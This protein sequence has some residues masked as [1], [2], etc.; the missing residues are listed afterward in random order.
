MANRIWS[1]LSLV[2]ALTVPLFATAASAQDATCRPGDLL[3][4]EV[5][6]GPFQGRVRVGPADPGPVV[7]QPPPVVVQPPPPPI[8]VQPPPPPVV[9]QP[10]PQPPVVVV[11]QPPP[12]PVIVRQPQVIETRVPRTRVVYD[13]VPAFDIGLHLQ[14][15][16][17]FSDRAGIGGGAAALRIRPAEWLG[18]DVGA[19]FYGGSDYQGSDHWEMPLTADLLFFFNPQDRFQIYALVGGGAS[20]GQSGSYYRAT[21]EFVP[22]RDL[23]YV[24]GEAGLG[25]EWRLGRH[26]A[27]NLDARWFLREQV[28]GGQE[29][30]EI[31]GGEVRTTNTSTGV[32]GNVGM[33]FYFVGL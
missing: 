20:F 8:V 17:L 9:V 19:G 5:Q 12:P 10:P 1:S 24:G 3:C 2:V 22:S 11:Q 31:S 21:D 30:S 29:F 18:I 7:V 23:T 33:T 28:G 27:L 4:G 14:L 25:L 16:G 6:V 32:T 26:F 13:Y 15:G